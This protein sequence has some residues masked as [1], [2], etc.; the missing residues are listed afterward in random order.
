MAR[1]CPSPWWYLAILVAVPGCASIHDPVHSQLAGRWVATKAETVI[2]HEFGWPRG[3]KTTTCFEASSDEVFR[4]SFVSDGRIDWRQTN[5]GFSVP[6]TAK[7][8]VR[9]DRTPVDAKEDGSQGG[10]Y[11]VRL[12]RYRK[13]SSRIII[14]TI[15]ERRRSLGRL[16]MESRLID[17]NTMRVHY[18][19]SR[20]PGARFIHESIIDMRRE[21]G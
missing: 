1:A 14:E 21:E 4:V 15:S 8:Y 9:G 18:R 6:K 7:L 19:L 11:E 12:A 5:I 17:D 13:D 2:W 10:Y 3:P 16:E 20:I